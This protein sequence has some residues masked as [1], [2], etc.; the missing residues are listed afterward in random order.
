MS[1]REQV[2]TL[3]RAEVAQEG[4]VTA[5]AIRLYVENRVSRAAFNQAIDEGMKA[6]G[7]A[8]V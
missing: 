5:R 7:G 4:K 1:R 2:L 6:R 8:K 3:I